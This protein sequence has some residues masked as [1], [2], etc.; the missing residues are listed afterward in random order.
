MNNQIKSY[1]SITLACVF[2]GLSFVSSKICLQWFSP[3]YLAF[4]RFFIAFIVLFIVII[5]KKIDLKITFNELIK[6][7]LMGFM[8][9]FLYFALEYY[10]L[11][12]ISASLACILSSILPALTIVSDYFVLKKPFTRKNI[13]S[14]IISVIG[15]CLVAGFSCEENSKNLILGIIL[16]L[17]SLVA[18]LI[19]SY[20]SAPMLHR[21]SPI[22]ITFYQTMFGAIFFAFT[23]PFNYCSIESIQLNGIFHLLF[24]AIFCSALC[25]VLYNHSLKYIDIMICS[26]FINLM[27][28]ITVFASIII[29]KEKLNFI[30]SI[31]SILIILSVFI[32]T[33]KDK[34]N[35][36]TM[37]KT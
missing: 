31:G 1:I 28:I 16:I 4:F 9:I 17:S 7:I 22:K 19:Y 30:Q 36:K 25:Y 5:Y 12:Y 14:V 27:P 10:A 20:F 33:K 32:A 35:K 15:A 13:F 8:G 18:W 23:I 29:L 21:Y 11:K 3:F 2:W 37:S 6:I 24:L 34:V 26:I